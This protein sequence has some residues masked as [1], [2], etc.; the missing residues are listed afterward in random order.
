M[1]RIMAR[2]SSFS[3][4]VDA[5]HEKQ[6]KLLTVLLRSLRNVELC[7]R[8]FVVLLGTQLHLSRRNQNLLK[9]EGFILQPA[10]P[11]IPGVP[12]ADKLLVWKLTQYT[13]V[14]VLD[15]DLMV[16]QP[17]DELFHTNQEFTIAH[18]PYDHLQAQC[19]VPIVSR[20]IAALFVMRP[21][22]ATYD[23]LLSYL[24]RRFKADQL[25]YAD[26]SGLM[27]FFGNRSRTLP[28]PY[29][30]DV[31]MTSHEWLPKW[32]KN[33]RLYAQQHVLKNC[34]PD[35]ADGCS[36]HTR[37][38]L[39]G[40]TRAHVVRACTW[41]AVA[42]GLHAVH[43][44]GTSKPWASAAHRTCRRLEIGRPGVRP[45]PGG[46]KQVTVPVSDHLEW[47]ATWQID[48]YPEVGACISRLWRLPV[49]WAGRSGTR[50]HRKCCT[51]YI[52][53][54]ARWNELWATSVQASSA[55]PSARSIAVL[56]GAG[57]T[58]AAGETAQSSIQQTV[59]AETKVKDP[60][61][62]IARLK[63]LLDMGAIST[64]AYGAKVAQ[65]MAQV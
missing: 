35:V 27:C 34:L 64:K 65:L 30:Y 33:C 55:T 24:L 2:N 43:F 46:S 45:L 28:C 9:R 62:K 38:D 23:A 16:V 36:A 15:A 21:H 56:A 42:S 37:H 29:V 22:V 19:N 49:Y 63:G 11:V 32:T 18:H 47:N 48:G 1:A 58:I 39:C 40:D 61:S 41:P 17:I 12:T 54:S 52:V 20:G 57:R 8:D 31:S 5:R 14:A 51:S 25:L 60:I 6:V 44:K 50:V 13:Q 53:M 7:R 3:S 26:Q 10:P 59:T 4:S